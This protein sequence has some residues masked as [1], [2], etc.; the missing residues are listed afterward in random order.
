MSQIYFSRK[1]FSLHP[2]LGQKQECSQI[3][4][5]MLSDRNRNVL[6]QEQECSQIGTGMFSNRNRN[7]LEQEQECPRTGKGTVMLLIKIIFYI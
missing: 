4:T 6:E 2:S 7:A 1:Q 5:G 3:G